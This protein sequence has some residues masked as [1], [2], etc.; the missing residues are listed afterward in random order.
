MIRDILVANPQAAKSQRVAD[1]LENRKDKLPAYMMA[2]IEAQKDEWG[3]ME[4]LQDK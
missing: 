2:H 4:L 3:E 1:A